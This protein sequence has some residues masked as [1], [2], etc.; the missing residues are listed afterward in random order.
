MYLPNFSTRPLFSRNYTSFI[1]KKSNI[2]TVNDNDNDNDNNY[3]ENFVAELFPSYEAWILPTAT[4][5]P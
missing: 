2:G 5:I 3:F 4:I 1:G